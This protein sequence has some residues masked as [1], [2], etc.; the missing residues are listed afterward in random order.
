MLPRI[1]KNMNLTVDGISHIGETETVTPPK[2]SRKTEAWRGG[3][4]AGAAHVDMGLDDDALKMEWTIGGYSKEV[5]TQIGIAK[6]DGT[7]LR[8][9]G[10]FQRDDTGQIS[11]VE[12]VARG[13]HQEADRGEFKVGDKNSTK[14]STNC[15]YYRETVDGVVVQ[16]VDVLNMV[17][18][19]NG[20]DV[21]K[22][23][24]QA[25]GA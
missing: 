12:I 15:V 17:H 8:F 16:E 11:T 6:I 24:R 14:V 3:G 9:S 22:E 20:V 4:M 5:M 1:L 23:M 19:V 25:I 7:A 13:R 2:L 21:L 18:I 10:A